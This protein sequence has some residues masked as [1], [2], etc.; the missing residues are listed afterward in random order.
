M[1][2]P[3]T[4]LITWIIQAHIPLNGEKLKLKQKIGPNKK[5]I[6]PIVNI[7]K[8]L[9]KSDNLLLI[10][11]TEKSYWW[12]VVI[13]FIN[14]HLNWFDLKILTWKSHFCQGLSCD[15]EI[16]ENEGVYV[17]CLVLIQFN[18]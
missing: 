17:G 14:Y 15:H 3:G 7:A 1:T 16:N 13:K 10:S 2:P 12:F 5:I 4:S 6:K 9:L 18:V 8:F 11:E